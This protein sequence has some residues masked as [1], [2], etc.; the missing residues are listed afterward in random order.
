MQPVNETLWV[1][2]QLA[3]PGITCPTLGFVAGLRDVPVRIHEADRT[4]TLTVSEFLHQGLQFALCIGP[5]PTPPVAKDVTRNHRNFTGDS[6]V[7][8]QQCR[9]IVTIPKKVKV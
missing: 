2:E 5:V 4:R 3:V 8:E 7:I 9:D 6:G 1:W